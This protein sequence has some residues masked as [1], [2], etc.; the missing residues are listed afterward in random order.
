MNAVFHKGGQSSLFSSLP[1]GSCCGRLLAPGFADS[2]P[3]DGLGITGGAT[4]PPAAVAVAARHCVALLL[5]LLMVLRSSRPPR[6][7]AAPLDL[8]DM[9][10]VSEAWGAGE[11]EGRR[12]S[13]GG[14]SRSCCR[15]GGAELQTSPGAASA[16]TERPWTP[17]PTRQSRPPCSVCH[18]TQRGG[19]VRPGGRLLFTA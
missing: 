15:H 18:G 13:R 12:W 9:S 8:C 17:V 5:L 7:T 10:P 2:P 16:R 1:R 11:K 4:C 19:R 3:V 6:G 14:G